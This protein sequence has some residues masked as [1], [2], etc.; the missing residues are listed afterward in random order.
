MHGLLLD[1][2]TSSDWIKG[3]LIVESKYTRKGLIFFYFLDF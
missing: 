1:T 2:R 3:K